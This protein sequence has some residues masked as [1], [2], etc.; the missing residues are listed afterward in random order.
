M[1]RSAFG[2]VGLVHGDEAVFA[3]EGRGRL[4]LLGPPRLVAVVEQDLVA[5]GDEARGDE[6]HGRVRARLVLQARV[7][8][9]AVVGEVEE[10]RDDD[11]FRSGEVHGAGGHESEREARRERDGGGVALVY[12]RENALR[13]L[14]GEAAYPA[15]LRPGVAAVSEHGLP[16]GRGPP[17]PDIRAFFSVVS[18]LRFGHDGACSEIPQDTR[19]SFKLFIAQSP[20][21]TQPHSNFNGIPKRWTPRAKRERQVDFRA[22]PREVGEPVVAPRAH[23]EPPQ[24]E[25]SR[26]VPSRLP[27]SIWVDSDLNF[28]RAGTTL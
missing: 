7:G 28:E 15:Q 6:F 17:A 5:R 26:D 24:R 2:R 27:V 16:D 8:S 19:D 14:F 11:P 3:E 12:A 1:E 21:Q 25:P 13:E 20:T 22:L 9:R 10:T 23:A 4:S 18:S